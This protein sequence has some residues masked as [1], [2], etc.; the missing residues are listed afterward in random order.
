MIHI[1]ILELDKF[2]IVA[3]FV[4]MA[5]IVSRVLFLSYRDVVKNQ[6]K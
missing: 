3:F 1:D 6:K 5:I 2:A 4:I